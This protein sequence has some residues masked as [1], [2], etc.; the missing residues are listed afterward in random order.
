MKIV[1]LLY[2]NNKLKTSY[3]EFGQK[4]DSVI[5]AR[6]VQYNLHIFHLGAGRASH[7]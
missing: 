6:P 1:L 3:I 7:P 4:T 5:F 2:I